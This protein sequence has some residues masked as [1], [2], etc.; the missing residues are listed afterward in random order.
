MKT[1]KGFLKESN[2]FRLL[3]E[4]ATGASTLFEG[5]IATC[6]N[7]S[8]LSKPKF[9]VEILKDR[10]YI[11]PFLKAADK[12]SGKDVFATKGKSKKEQ[13]EILYKF[14]QVCK[15]ALKVTGSDAG[16]GQAKRQVS[17]PWNQQTG[18]SKDTSKA[19]IKVGTFQTSVKGPSA[20]LMSGKKDE[21]KATILAALEISKVSGKLKSKLLD[22]VE[23][24]VDNTRTVGEEINSGILK[25]MSVADAKKSGNE[26]AKKI[27]DNQD[28]MKANIQKTFEDAFKDSKVGTAF[29]YEAMTGYEKFGGK[30]YPK[31]KAGDAIGEATHMLIWDYRMDRMKL[32]KIDS[33]FSAKTAKKMNIRPDLKSSSYDIKG[34]K[35]GYNF[36]QAMRVSVGVFLDQQGK[37]VTEAQ[38]ALDDSN[39]LLAEGNLTELEL[40]RVKS[41]ITKTMQMFREKV[42]SLW[43]NLVS[44]ITEI[45]EKARAFFEQ[46]IEYV[47]NHFQVDVDVKV[48]PVVD[49]RL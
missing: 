30:A 4:S 8:N 32:Q 5:V 2:D 47:M 15:K 39:R 16:F 37:V 24:F 11:L 46:G 6:H 3:A 29:A 21:T 48:N 28:K 14:S 7:L 18:K 26:A 13:V 31:R 49:F 1:L 36:Y 9:E 20:Q 44:K 22:T 38:A 35:S 41:F 12:G 45:V 43:N 33:A 25:K 40:K 19:D 10:K 27:I 34:V 23:S 17:E 42:L